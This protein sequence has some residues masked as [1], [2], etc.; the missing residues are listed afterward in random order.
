MRPEAPQW[1]PDGKYLYFVGEKPGSPGERDYF[2]VPATGGRMQ[3]LGAMPGAWGRLS[4][5]GTRIAYHGR[6]RG[7]AFIY[8]LPATGGPSRRIT[9]D[10]S[11]VYQIV[12]EWTNNDSV[13]VIQSYD[14]A[15][16]RDAADLVS[17]RLA[18]G[19]WEQLTR[20]AYGAEEVWGFTPD[21][22]DILVVRRTNRQQLRRVS[23]V[24]LVS[25]A[26]TEK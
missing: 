9:S 3:G 11:D 26:A 10:T 21:G 6:E 22:K 16:N 20:T 5:D 4:H 12:P 18:N 19:K 25:A 14:L 24:N 2:R 1:S 13:L 7:W 8:E 15:G 17:Y 23:V